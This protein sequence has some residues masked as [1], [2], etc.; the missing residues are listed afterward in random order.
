M[1]EAGSEENFEPQRSVG[2][3]DNLKEAFRRPFHKFGSTEPVTKL[4]VNPI[5]AADVSETAT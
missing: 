1:L 3:L 5:N 4:V 2:H